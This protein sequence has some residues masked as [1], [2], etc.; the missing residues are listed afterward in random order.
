MSISHLSC[1]PSVCCLH[2][3]PLLLLFFLLGLP[4]PQPSQQRL[5]HTHHSLCSSLGGGGGA[6]LPPPQQ[7]QVCHAGRSQP[8]AHPV[9]S[10]QPL[11]AARVPVHSC[12]HSRGG[13]GIHW[14][15]GPTP[16]SHGTSVP[17]LWVPG[18]GDPI[19]PSLHACEHGEDRDFQCFRG[20]G[21]GLC[22][23]E[24]A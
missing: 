13:G 18:S 16:L 6:G 7:V 1:R 20:V 15:A 21:H 4:P 9:C 19:P 10:Q 22:G 5:P 11:P 14:G 12:H 3:A 24:C 2:P 17:V 23:Q 8:N